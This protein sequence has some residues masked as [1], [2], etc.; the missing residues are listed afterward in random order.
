MKNQEILRKL[1]AQELGTKNVNTSF[2]M[3][4]LR[5]ETMFEERMVEEIYE[6]ERIFYTLQK[7]WELL[8]CMPTKYDDQ[9]QKEVVKLIEKLH[10][11]VEKLDVIY[12]HDK[13]I[14]YGILLNMQDLLPNNAEM[15]D[16]WTMLINKVK[17]LQSIDSMK[18]NR[19]T[20]LLNRL[21]HYTRRFTVTLRKP[22]FNGEKRQ[23]YPSEYSQ[24]VY[25]RT[26]FKHFKECRKFIMTLPEELKKVPWMT[27][28]QVERMKKL[29]SEWH[30]YDEYHENLNYLDIL[31]PLDSVNKAKRY[32]KDEWDKGKKALETIKTVEKTI[33]TYIDNSKII[34]PYRYTKVVDLIFRIVV[35]AR[36]DNRKYLHNK[37]RKKINTILEHTVF[38]YDIQ[39][40]FVR[41]KLLE[42]INQNLAGNIDYSILN[43]YSEF[44]FKK[45]MLYKKRKKCLCVRI[46]PD[47]LAV[48]QAIRPL[49]ENEYLSGRDFWL[50]YIFTTDTKTRE[51]LWLGICD[52]WPAYRAAW[53]VRQTYPSGAYNNLLKLAKEFRKSK[54]TFEKY[55]EAVNTNYPDA[56]PKSC[57][58][59]KQ[60]MFDI[61]TT[62]LLPE[63][64]ILQAVLRTYENK[65]TKKNKTTPIC[66]YGH[67]LPKTL[68]LGINLNDLENTVDEAKSNGH[69]FLNGS[70]RWMTDYDEAERMGMA[71]TL[72]LDQFA[73]EQYAISELKK[74]INGKKQVERLQKNQL[75]PKPRSFIFDA[76]YVF[77]ANNETVDA[78]REKLSRLLN[79]HLYSDKGYSLLNIGTATNILTDEDQKTNAERF[80]TNENALIERYKHVPEN[81]ISSPKLSPDF[82]LLDELFDH[83]LPKANF[84]SNNSEKYCDIYN[85]RRANAALIEAVENKI[86]ELFRNNDVLKDFL[87][88]D[89]LARGPFPP[90]RIGNQPYGILPICDFR[91]LCF[92][93]YID[94]K[95][96]KLNPLYYLHQI[97]VYLT[98]K[99]N[100]IADN[101]VSYCDG[102]D[103]VTADDFL[104]IAGSTPVSSYFQR[105]QSVKE[106]HNNK[107]QDDKPLLLQPEFFKFTDAKGNTEFEQPE[108]LEKI[109]SILNE[110]KNQTTT[111]QVISYLNGFDEIPIIEDDSQNKYHQNF[112][113]L[114]LPNLVNYLK[115]KKIAK[116]DEEAKNYII[117]FFDL[118]AYRLD[119]WM[120]GLLSNK[121]REKIDAKQHQIALG[122]YGWVFNLKETN[123]QQ[124]HGEYILAPSV[125]QAITGAVL[126]SSYNNSRI[127][128]QPDYDLNVN[129]SSERV[130]NALRI[131][132]G[133]QNGL[134]IGTILGT[135]LERLMHDAY[136]NKELK[137]LVQL[138]DKEQLEL[139]EGIYK[140]RQHYP[141][142]KS[143]SKAQDDIKD[144]D[145]T[146]VNG[147][148]L[149]EDYRSQTNK[150]EFIKKLKL[151]SKGNT[152]K[153]NEALRILLNRIDDEYDALTDVVL[154]EGVYKL[155]QGQREAVDAL[156]QAFDTGKNIPMPE[157]AEIPISSAQVDGSLV[158]ALNPKVNATSDAPLLARIEPKVDLWLKETLVTDKVN[159]YF[160]NG[161]TYSEPKNMQDL[162]VSSSEMVYLSAN[163]SAFLRYLELKNWLKSGIYEDFT[164]DIESDG[165]MTFD[166]VELMLD[167]MREL[168]AGARI[169]RNDD[170]VKETGLPDNADY[171]TKL[172]EDKYQNI[173]LHEVQELT[174]KIFKLL[175]K[176]K[177]LQDPSKENYDTIAIDDKMMGEALSLATQCFSI[178]Q[179]TAM[180]AVCKELLVGK[181][182]LYGDGNS[183]AF[184]ETVRLQHTFFEKMETIYENLCK[185]RE[186]AEQIVNNAKEKTYRTYTE[187]IQKLLV[188]NMLIVPTF[189]PD[190]NVPLALLHE[191]KSL[192]YFKNVTSL[193][194]DENIQSLS[195]VSPQMMRFHQLRLFQKWNT[196]FE[197]KQ[198][199]NPFIVEADIVPMQIPIVGDKPM[200]LGTEVDNEN[201]VDDAFTYMVIK[202]TNFP[203]P[204]A[205]KPLMAGIVLDHW[206]E[207]IPYKE[208]TAGL[209]FNFDQPDAEAPQALLLAVSTRDRSNHHWSEVMLLNTLRSAMHLV[210]CR[211]VEPD[212]LKKYPW[213]A[214]LFPLIN[215]TDSTK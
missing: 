113:N 90:I 172:L 80:D 188:S 50:N 11:E 123:K 213:T 48:T 115:S 126:R 202:P 72:P 5:L 134:A 184:L 135:D 133:V 150:Q 49:S 152:N 86:V 8:C 25:Y 125:N 52:L 187:A 59:D 206:I 120:M 105:V 111:N 99:W 13:C 6:P 7:A 55:A 128:N 57:V 60:Q 43:K 205:E 215:Y 67:R 21:E 110:D 101:I 65:K 58:D 181:N 14:F 137:Q 210:K 179:T 196:L 78:C 165:S 186:E 39:R 87:S 124:K 155:T 51:S 84:D 173:A 70:L 95:E 151:F 32:L 204:N 122:H 207:R 66:K 157:V 15:K 201:Y 16:N 41:E 24:S 69:I 33:E 160:Q 146:V 180:D 177:E 9:T 214:G 163:K 40:E 68:Q 167:N 142:V 183:K 208:Q 127:N 19:A 190:G 189:V 200:W 102:Y 141:M 185:A 116:S 28:E 76:V 53:I 168:L 100:Y 36:K 71:I 12:E 140:L 178:G 144:N 85:S 103:K 27:I 212:D 169:L 98:E 18:Y 166:E 148:K 54:K 176:Q 161:D 108:V 2:L 193:T 20:D 209:S 174:A 83:T 104:K 42:W 198:H 114:E 109:L 153:K 63:R 175:N 10:I 29:L 45:K 81:R 96:K 47:E 97:L 88:N 145:I 82:E 1:T 154:S 121:L 17:R 107:E 211:S 74:V 182:T 26:R 130:R 195:K 62:D 31:T 147:A 203:L 35:N 94:F 119:A 77:G 56:F 117:E 91:N 44:V 156:M 191:Q 138:D 164:S 136:K 158:V 199:Q 92:N 79:A 37:E 197:I 3:M 75:K 93:K 23:S 22:P 38:D 143:E 132:E 131:I 149:I 129:L 170:L 30:E 118:F 64:F 4:P 171:M 34:P 73:Y 106:K 112:S 159:L 61:P 162:G 192:Q 89:V 139:D 194:V 46:Y